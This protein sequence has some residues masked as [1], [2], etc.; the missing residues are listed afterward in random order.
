[1]EEELLY[2]HGGRSQISRLH[3]ARRITESLDAWTL[4][5]ASYGTGAPLARAI[6]RRIERQV[7]GMEY[8]SPLSTLASV[9]NYCPGVEDTSNDFIG[10]EDLVEGAHVEVEVEFDISDSSSDGDI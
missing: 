5:N 9:W 3:N 6:G 8:H 7:A 4:G 1:M 2:Y 10:E